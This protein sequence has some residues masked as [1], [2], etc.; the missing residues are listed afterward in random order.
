M[1]SYSQSGKAFV[2]PSQ[3]YSNDVYQKKYGLHPFTIFPPESQNIPNTTENG[4]ALRATPWTNVAQ[5]ARQLE[6]L[7]LSPLK[8]KKQLQK[9]EKIKHN[10]TS[11]SFFFWLFVGLKRVAIFC[12]PPKIGRFLPSKKNQSTT[13]HLRNS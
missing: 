1:K 8:L 4:G 10:S 3:K 7:Q 11:P 5:H 2:K 9:L 6:T 12:L 13:C